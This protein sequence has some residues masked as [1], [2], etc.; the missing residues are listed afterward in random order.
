MPRRRRWVLQEDDGWSSTV[1]GAVR[2]DRV[3]DDSFDEMS[4]MFDRLE[5]VNGI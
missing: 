5:K 4:V 3:V 2:C 1:S